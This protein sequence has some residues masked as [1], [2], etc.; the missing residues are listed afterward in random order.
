MSDKTL[1]YVI[2]ATDKDIRKIHDFNLKSFAD[3][4]MSWTYDSL[5]KLIAKGWELRT[6]NYNG[7]IV[8]AL[9]TKTEGDA[10][11]TRNTSIAV[12]F[13]GNGFSHMIK[14]HFEDIA[15]ESNLK[16]VI[17]Y[18]P[19]DNFRM[20]SLNERH[21]YEKTG[22]RLPESEEIMEWVKVI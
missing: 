7:D 4:D 16:K 18:C 21:H 14:D 12:D 15:Y 6:A 22:N 2:V 19:F 13:Q 1:D 3:E 10:L 11:L 17:N 5:K 8:A 20:I 9:F